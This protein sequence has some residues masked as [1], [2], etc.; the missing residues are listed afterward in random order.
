[1]AYEIELTRAAAREFKK[2]ER[3][4][5]V[6]LKDAIDALADDPRPGGVKKLAGEDN[7]WRVRVGDYRIIYSIYEDRL[8]VLVVRLRHRKDAY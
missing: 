6:R 2:L 5:Q 7:L 8:I 3:T 1:M 4:V